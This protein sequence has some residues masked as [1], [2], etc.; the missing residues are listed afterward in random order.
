MIIF[1]KIQILPLNKRH[2]WHNI[3]KKKL[4]DDIFVLIP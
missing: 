1:I 2:F 4:K 3:I